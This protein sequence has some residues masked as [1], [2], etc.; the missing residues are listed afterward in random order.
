MAAKSSTA[1]A[2]PNPFTTALAEEAR[3]AGLR[4]SSD[5]R[6]GIRRRRRGDGFVFIDPAGKRIT[7]RTTLGRIKRLAIPPAWE[8]V[9]ICPHENGHIQATGRDARGR[10]QYRYHSHWRAQRDEN[11]F[12]RMIAFARALPRIR[13]RVARDL[14]RRG[15]PREKVLATVVRLLEATLIRVGNDEYA[16]HNRSYGLTTMQDRHVKVAG[17]KIQFAFRGKGGIRHE[18]S[19]R[20][21]QLAKIV[22]RS[23]DLPG[24][25]LFAYEGED[26][27]PRDIGSQDVNEYL[28]QIAGTDFSAKDFRTWAGTVLAAIALREFEEVT[29]KT[30]AKKNVVTAIEAVARTL[31]NTPAVCRKCYIHPAIVDS[32]LAGDTIATLRQRMASKIDR[33]LAA[34]KPEE[35]AVL[36]LLQRKLQKAGPNGTARKAKPPARPPRSSP[37]SV[38]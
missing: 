12:G 19:V 36:I 1:S 37:S 14:R 20:D 2:L 5:R 23:R 35:A 34:L 10:K 30:Q 9:W 18:I 24:Q 21:P 15:M 32:Y 26:G 33:S 8:D 27:Q 22:R 7:D 16:R 28:R 17:P 11:K 29:G 38:R 4:Y 25:E 31:G 3:D 6:P 13:R